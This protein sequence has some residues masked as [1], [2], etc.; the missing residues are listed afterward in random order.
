[1][2]QA[3]AANQGNAANYYA[4]ASYFIARI[5]VS[6]FHGGSVGDYSVLRLYGTHGHLTASQGIP[7]GD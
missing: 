6:D 5:A 4:I 2:G 7:P 1:V 3:T